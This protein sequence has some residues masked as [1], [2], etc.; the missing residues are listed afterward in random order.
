MNVPPMQKNLTE[1]KA[2]A[3]GASIRVSGFNLDIES[4]TREIGHIPTHTHRQG[5]LNQLKE[6]YKADMWSLKSPLGSD[7]PLELI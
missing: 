2:F 6:P 4:V 3:A 5:E 7:Q 1:Q